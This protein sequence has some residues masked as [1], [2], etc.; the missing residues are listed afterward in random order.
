MSKVCDLKKNQI[1]YMIEHYR[2][3]FGMVVSHLP[4]EVHVYTFKNKF[5][6]QN[7]ISTG[8]NIFYL[9]SLEFP[10]EKTYL[11]SDIM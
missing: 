11:N 3:T 7:D 4:G 2:T 1:V 10:T 6:W 8:K 9:W 5:R